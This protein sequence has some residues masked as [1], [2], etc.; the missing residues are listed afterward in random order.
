LI[1]HPQLHRPEVVKVEVKID[2][3]V[4][5]RL[6]RLSELE[7]RPVAAVA[8]DRLAA[9]VWLREEELDLDPLVQPDDEPPASGADLRATVARPAWRGLRWW[10]RPVWKRG[11]PVA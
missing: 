7:R 10:L 6:D 5:A 11:P 9:G 4:R 3:A 1:N 8:A 2:A